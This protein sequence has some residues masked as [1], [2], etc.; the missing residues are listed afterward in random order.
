M[1]SLLAF[2]LAFGLLSFNQA[3]PVDL[4]SVD[5]EKAP[6]SEEIHAPKN[7]EGIATVD[8]HE[9]IKATV[10]KDESKHVYLLVS[11]IGSDPA[12]AKTWW[13][14]REVTKSGA[15]VECDCQFGEDDRGKGQFFAIV[16]LVTPE[17]FEV[18]QTMEK[19]PTEGKYSKVRIVKRK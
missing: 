12:A 18:G 13:V 1:R 2:F 16:A 7:D 14:Q 6:S 10:A 3:G 5:Q 4:G 8:L 17:S 9:T 15:T 19:L 11:P